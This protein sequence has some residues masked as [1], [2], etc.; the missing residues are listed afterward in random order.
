MKDLTFKTVMLMA[1]TNAARVD[2]IHKLSVT[3]VQKLK[4]EFIVPIE[5]L[6]KQS[7][8]G[9]TCKH[10]S[11]KAFPPDRRLCIYTVLKEYLKRTKDLRVGSKLLISYVKPHHAVTTDTVARW[12]RTVMIKSGINVKKFGPHSYRTAAS[13][14]ASEKCVPIKEILQTG[15]W[16]NVGTFAKFCQKHIQT[17][18]GFV[19]SVLGK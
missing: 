15:G 19:S 7:R 1:L 13:S 3:N 4:T 17:G 16:S 14:K 2:T 18:T 5:G 11:F 12:L 8:P 9:F 10:L 6:L